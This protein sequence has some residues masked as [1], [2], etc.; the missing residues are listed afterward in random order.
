MYVCMYVCICTYIYICVYIHT[1]P[2]T[3]NFNRESR[4]LYI[5]GLKLLSGLQCVANVLLMCC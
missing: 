3:G 1:Y 4:T 2:G 5:G